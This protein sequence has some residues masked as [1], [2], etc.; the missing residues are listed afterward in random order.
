MGQLTVRIPDD[1]LDRVRTVA[2]SRGFSM[3]EYAVRVLGA[4]TDPDLAGSEIDRLRERLASAG[5]LE[6]PQPRRAGRPTRAR[7]DAARAAAGAGRTLA[8]IV[9]DGR[10]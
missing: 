1:L 10:G 7:L 9:S 2:R 3:N 4:A 6:P 5:L 8:D